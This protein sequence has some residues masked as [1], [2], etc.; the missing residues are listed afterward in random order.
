MSEESSNK[1]IAKN[2]LLLYFRMVFL[3]G[4]SFYTTRAILQALGVVDLG[5]Y[6]VVGGVVAMFGFVNGSLSSASSRFVTYS[7]GKGDRNDLHSTFNTIVT[8]HFLFA[9]AILI[10]VELGGLWFLYNKLVIPTDRLAAAFWVFQSAVVSSVMVIMT[11]PFN[12]DIIAH[13]KM[14]AFAY[15][16]IFEAISKLLIVFVLFN[17]EG[18]KLIVYSVLLVVVQLIVASI[19]VRYCR[20]HFTESKFRFEWNSEKIRTIFSYAGW[21][22]TGSFAFI[23]CTQGL[24]IILNLFFGPAVNAARALANQ[25]QGAINQF[26]TNFQTAV[27]PQITK[28]YAGGD[29]LRMHSLVLAS[30]KFGAFLMTMILI[31]VCVETEFILSIWLKEVPD[32]TVQFVQIMLFVGVIGAMKDPTMTAI[33]ATGNIKKAEIVEMVFMLSLLPIAYIALSLFSITPEFTMLIYLL[34]ELA[35]QIARVWVIYPRVGLKRMTYL[36][37]ILTPTVLVIIVSISLSFTIKQ[38]FDSSPSYNILIMIISELVTIVTICLLGLNISEKR[39]VYT[40]IKALVIK[41]NKK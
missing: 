31:P 6:N 5:I 38:M 30:T 36:T 27:K 9:A 10:L 37:R 33:H 24:N 2:T 40:K 26:T 23:C 16:S 41:I 25:L 21:V 20:T 22:M 17:I 32:H 29:L 28:T 1:R 8:V 18:D 15:I 7:L 19:Y 4:I 11:A 3:L 14:S 35:T 12:A 13:E 34:V 39:L